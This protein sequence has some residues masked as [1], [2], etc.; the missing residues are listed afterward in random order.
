MKE[1]ENVR[2]YH[3]KQQGG[4]FLLTAA[5]GAENTPCC[6]STMMRG[7][8]CVSRNNCTNNTA[9]ESTSRAA[10]P[11]SANTGQWCCPFPVLVS[12]QEQKNIELSSK[13]EAYTRSIKVPDNIDLHSNVASSN[14][15][16]GNC[17]LREKKSKIMTR[18]DANVDTDV[19]DGYFYERSSILDQNLRR[20]SRDGCL[21]E[22]NFD[23]FSRN[24]NYRGNE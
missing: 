7:R 17:T 1:L 8:I 6:A 18:N 11:S 19:I 13:N 21:R 23:D 4:Q 16:I 12:G 14:D 9:A 10:V 22:Q 20:M 5:T 3:Q 24:K 15:M 2:N